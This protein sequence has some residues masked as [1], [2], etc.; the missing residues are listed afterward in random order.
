MIILVK[1]IHMRCIKIEKWIG[2]YRKKFLQA[3]CRFTNKITQISQMFDVLRNL[4]KYQ[5]NLR[6]IKYFINLKD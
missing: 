5:Q 4:R 2:I 6:E 1:C 3:S